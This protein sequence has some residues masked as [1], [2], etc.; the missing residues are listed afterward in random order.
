MTYGVYGSTAS[1]ANN[2]AGVRG[3]DS[4]GAGATYGTEGVSIGTNPNAAAIRGLGNG[5]AGPGVPRAAALRIENGVITVAGPAKTADKITVS[6]WTCFHAWDDESDCNNLHYGRAPIGANA[7]ATITN[8]LIRGDS[9]LYLTVRGG[10]PSPGTSCYAQ[11]LSQSPGTAQIRVTV[12]GG[13]T[14]QPCSYS[15]TVDVNYLIIN[16]Q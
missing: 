10:P 13:P 11:V 1:V 8:S 2:A 14:C 16:P 4:G 5:A 15:G 9:L 6:G 12:L 7:D 3:T